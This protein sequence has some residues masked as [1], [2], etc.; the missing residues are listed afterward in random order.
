[1]FCVY[2]NDLL[3]S[4]ERS[5]NGC[6]IGPNYCGAFGYADDVILLC[7]SVNASTD[8][9]KICE[10]YASDH[11]IQFNLNK[12]QVILF[13][14]RQDKAIKCD[15]YLD[16]A[17]IPILGKVKYLGHVWSNTITG[18]IDELYI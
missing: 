13:P 6:H 15:F 10:K 8:M 14:Y 18:M 7:P 17:I 2:I 5:G 1:M 16:N 9:L 12:S 11:N 4:L 3:V